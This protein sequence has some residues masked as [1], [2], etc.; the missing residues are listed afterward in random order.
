MSSL[1]R[2]PMDSSADKLG[3]RGWLSLNEFVKY[4]KAEHPDHY[5]S[6]PTALSMVREGKIRALTV[7]STY[8]IYQ[9]EVTR[10]LREGNFDPQQ[11]R[12][13]PKE[14]VETAQAQSQLVR[15]QLKLVPQV[16]LPEE[17][18]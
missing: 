6:Y 3:K 16:P 17:D 14:V 8:R 5:V 12:G 4:L 9:E 2:T 13:I 10:Y 11:L 1:Q 15:P 18:K 7:G